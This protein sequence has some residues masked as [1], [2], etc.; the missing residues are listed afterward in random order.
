MDAD[1]TIK[2]LLVDDHPLV[3]DGIR[4]RLEHE[5]CIQVV[6]EANNGE[7]ALSLAAH[8]QPDVVLMDISMPVMNGLEATRCF[9]ERF[10]KI[11]V[12]ILSMHDNQE[13]I[14][15]IMQSGASG[16][17]LKDV[18]SQEM[19]G[20]IISV[21]QGNCYYSSG[22]SQTLLDGY[23]RHQNEPRILTRREEAVLKLLAQGKNTKAIGRHLDI[24]PR[25]VE[26]HRQNIKRKLDI[27]TPTG[28]AKYAI[29]HG[30]T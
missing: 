2:V 13:Y 7:Q 16:Y 12:L 8:L 14:T 29:E 19:V 27:H 3:L 10:P 25:T 26:T 21:H 5:R 20:A 11:R 9:H 1:K 30:L 6:G 15:S 4:A 28:L 23:N 24:S 22:V 17:I 18:S